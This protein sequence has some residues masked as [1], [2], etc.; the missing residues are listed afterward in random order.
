MASIS[1]EA[2]W[3][4]D[5]LGQEEDELT[6]IRAQLSAQTQVAIVTFATQGYPTWDVVATPGAHRSPAGPASS[7]S[8]A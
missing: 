6:T 2:S 1:A 4:H 8:V 7:M 5:L 3:L